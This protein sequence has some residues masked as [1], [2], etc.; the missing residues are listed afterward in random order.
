MSIFEKK[1]GTKYF[2]EKENYLGLKIFKNQF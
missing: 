2:D 1:K